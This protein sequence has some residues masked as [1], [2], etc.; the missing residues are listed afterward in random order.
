MLPVALNGQFM[1]YKI[2]GQKCFKIFGIY[3]FKCIATNMGGKL[4]L[5]ITNLQCSI[6]CYMSPRCLLV[7]G[8]A[9]LAHPCMLLD[10]AQG[11]S[12]FHLAS[13]AE[14]K[15]NISCTR[16]MRKRSRGGKSPKRIRCGM[17]HRPICI[18]MSLLPCKMGK[19]AVAAMQTTWLLLDFDTSLSKGDRG[20]LDKNNSFKFQKAAQ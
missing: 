11:G 2:R 4:T 5:D 6:Q 10:A 9:K 13:S 15:S 3:A 19:V 17:F 20:V 7:A 1:V 16:V 8:N 18:Q 12:G 14:W